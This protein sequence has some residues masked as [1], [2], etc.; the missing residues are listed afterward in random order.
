MA[1]M[2]SSDDEEFYL[3]CMMAA[4]ADKQKKE[5][6]EDQGR[7][8]REWECE[9]VKKRDQLGSYALI[10]QEL[11]QDAK[12]FKQHTRLTPELFDILLEL[13]EPAIQKHDTQMRKSIPA[14]EPRI[15]TFRPV[16]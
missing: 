13:V 14:G 6:E 10:L 15:Y 3:Y 7:G 12:K 8:K 9:L 4:V 5:E 2:D 11:R 1:L 16:L